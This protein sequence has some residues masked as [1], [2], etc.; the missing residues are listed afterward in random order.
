M[1]IPLARNGLRRRESER[2]LKNEKEK[3]KRAEFSLDRSIKADVY[4]KRAATCSAKRSSERIAC[5][6]RGAPSAHAGSNSS[7]DATRKAQS[8]RDHWRKELVGPRPNENATEGVCRR[9]TTNL[10]LD[11]ISGNGIAVAASASTNGRD[12][13]ARTIPPSSCS[14]GSGTTAC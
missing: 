7:L 4:A 2:R 12:I 3:K 5:P 14:R 6:P 10:F 9:A 1:A 13:A 8:N 11:S